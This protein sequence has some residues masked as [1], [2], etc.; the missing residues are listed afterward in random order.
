MEVRI[1]RGYNGVK[2]LRVFTP[3][4]AITIYPIDGILMDDRPCYICSGIYP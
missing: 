2:D 4:I 3:N 1:E